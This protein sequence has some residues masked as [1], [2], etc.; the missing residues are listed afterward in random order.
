MAI[1]GDRIVREVRR[2]ISSRVIGEVDGDRFGETAD[3]LPTDAA[4]QAVRMLRATGSVRI[5]TAA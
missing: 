4:M 2:Q 3:P 5:H 1:V